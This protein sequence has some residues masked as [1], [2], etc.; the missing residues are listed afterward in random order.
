MKNLKFQFFYKIITVFFNKLNS[1]SLFSI[2]IIW[3]QETEKVIENY[4]SF[5]LFY[6]LLN[7]TYA[8]YYDNICSRTHE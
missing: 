1:N 8:L 2:T 3:K 6:T 7:V 4:H 5:Y